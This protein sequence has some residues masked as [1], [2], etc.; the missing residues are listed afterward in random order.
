MCFCFPYSMTDDWF[1]SVN[2]VELQL[3]NKTIDFLL[4][5]LRNSNAPT[6]LLFT[7]WHRVVLYKH[8]LTAIDRTV[9]AFGNESLKEKTTMHSH[10]IAVSFFF[11]KSKIIFFLRKID[12][13]QCILKILLSVIQREI[14]F[15]N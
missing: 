4:H 5:V 13:T 12:L 7:F 10:I 14:T 1:S 3:R 15:N 8:T 6:P 2:H 11:F 9:S